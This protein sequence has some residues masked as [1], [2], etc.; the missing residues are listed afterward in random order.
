MLAG[1]L[2]P[3]AVVALIA[4]VIGAVGNRVRGTTTW[5]GRRVAAA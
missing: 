3:L 2:Y 5:K 1:L 4:V